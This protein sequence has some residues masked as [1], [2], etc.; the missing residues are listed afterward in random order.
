MKR[1]YEI[2]RTRW[3]RGLEGF[4]DFVHLGDIDPADWDPRSV[5][6]LSFEPIMVPG[7]YD[8]LPAWAGKR[9]TVLYRQTVCLPTS[10][11]YR[12]YL[13]GV[14]HYSRIWAAGECLG[15]HAGGYTGFYFDF[16]IEEKMGGEVEILILVNNTIDYDRNPLH[17]EYFDWYHYGGIARGVE[18][19]R[20]ED[21]WIEAARVETIDYMKRRIRLRLEVTAKVG[22][23]FPLSISTETRDLLSKELTLETGTQTLSFDFELPDM[24]LWSPDE[25]HL[26]ILTVG[27]GGD[28]LRVRFGIR[29]VECRGKHILINGKRVELFGFNRHESHPHFGSALPPDIMLADLQIMKD[30][31]C[32]FLRGSHYPQDPRLMDLCDEFGILVWCEAVGWQH[33]DEHLSDPHF[34][35]HQKRN[36]TEM[37]TGLGNHPSIIMWGLLNESWSHYEGARKGYTTLISHIRESDPTRP[38]TYASNHY[39]QD[40]NF[41]LIDIVSFNCYPGWYMN[42]IDDIPEYL[43][44]I[45]KHVDDSGHGGKPVILSEIGAGALYGFRDRNA[46]RWSEE[47]Q[48]ALL[49]MV[50][51][52][53]QANSDRLC[54]LALWQYCDCRASVDTGRTLGRPRGFNNKGIVDEWRRPKSAYGVVKKLMTGG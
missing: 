11:R 8:A 41:D 26:G 36:I 39:F 31:G 17:L 48:A 12:L 18:I 52:Y 1:R 54:G 15:S 14:Q 29:R 46:A 51:T 35:K 47:Y 9:G 23:T 37:I 7:C 44:S 22:T 3:T 49:E 45:L 50:V 24:P 6:D 10:G 33:S 16:E 28:D 32:N 30:L 27:L 25:P 2:H 38:V 43:D 53:W 5:P 4:W 13:N 20:L 42:E 19:H 21:A 34:I 40:L